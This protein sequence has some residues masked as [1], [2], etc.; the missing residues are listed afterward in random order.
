M[1]PLATLLC[2]LLAVSAGLLLGWRIAARPRLWPPVALAAVAFV[3]LWLYAHYL[4]DWPCRFVPW[5]DWCF[6]ERVP[7]VFSIFVILGICLRSLQDRRLLRVALATIAVLFAAHSVLDIGS[8]L[9][10]RSALAALDSDAA[11]RGPVSQTTGWSCSAAAGAT[12]LRL[13]AIPASERQVAELA[14]TSPLT[15]TDDLGLCRAIEIL[16]EPR[17]LRPRLRAGLGQADLPTLRRPCLF[18]YRLSFTVW[19]TA[20]L[21]SSQGDR[22]EVEDPLLGRDTWTREDFLRKWVGTAVELE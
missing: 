11:G 7:L 14:G 21:V 2:A 13:H 19:H 16:G 20:V 12:F 10:F 5:R 18:G 3:A 6:F 1:L 8:P 4:T 22:L 15:G 9:I 17:G